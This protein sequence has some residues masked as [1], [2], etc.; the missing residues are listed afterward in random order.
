M[1]STETDF[2]IV[3]VVIGTLL[4]GALGAALVGWLLMLL[5]GILGVFFSFWKCWAIAYLA[6]ILVNLVL[7]PNRSSG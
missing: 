4:I 6:S 7:R 2:S 1:S 5:L 3:G